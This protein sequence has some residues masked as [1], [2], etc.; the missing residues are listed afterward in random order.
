MIEATD[1]WNAYWDSGTGESSRID[2]VRNE[3]FMKYIP[4]ADK[5]A[6]KISQRLPRAYSI[7]QAKSDAYTAI[8][9]SIPKFEYGHN[10]CFETFVGQRI[11]G[12]IMDSLRKQDMLSRSARSAGYEMHPLEIPVLIQEYQAFSSVLYTETKQVICEN[13]PFDDQKLL[14]YLTE[15]RVSERELL[16]SFDVSR[17]EMIIWADRCLKDA[18]TL[19]CQHSA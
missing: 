11:F 2:E 3:L 5:V 18:R 1:E 9:E 13:L 14:W 17:A 15:N 7:D 12:E 8:L 10:A 6:T 4:F 16:K 19:L